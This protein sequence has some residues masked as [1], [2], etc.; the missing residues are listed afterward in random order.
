MKR[1]KSVLTVFIIIALCL[2]P[3]SC[4]KNKDKDKNG[5]KESS[6]TEDTIKN[7]ET[8]PQKDILDNEEKEEEE[9]EEAEETKDSEKQTE[10][11]E[12]APEYNVT[13][14][15]GSWINDK[16]NGFLMV[17]DEGSFNYTDGSD[18]T[19]DGCFIIAENGSILAKY[20]GKTAEVT[21]GDESDITIEGLGVFIRI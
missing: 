12:S 9:K 13:L 10:E 17:D 15:S 8:E 20:A 6:R 11:E 14:F 1:I 2:A 3:V 18:E 4:T 7:N 19:I 5:A 21:I 16:E